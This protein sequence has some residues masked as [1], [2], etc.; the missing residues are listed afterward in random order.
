M[1]KRFFFFLEKRRRQSTDQ[2]IDSMLNN[3]YM[4][5]R[6]M[7]FFSPCLCFSLF[8]IYIY[9]YTYVFLRYYHLYVY[10]CVLSKKARCTEERSLSFFIFSFLSLF[11]FFFFV[12]M[13]SIFFFFPRIARIFVRYNICI[14]I[15]IVSINY[16]K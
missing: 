5:V 2:S 14:Y 7:Y 15:H 16:G 6:L 8:F 9:T 10:V 1:L 11:S 13:R 4:Y 12:P 3:L